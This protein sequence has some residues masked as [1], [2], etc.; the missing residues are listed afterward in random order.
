MPPQ[1]GAMSL[2][3]VAFRV[4]PSRCPDADAAICFWLGVGFRGHQPL[5]AMSHG[6]P[7]Q[8][9]S[10]QLSDAEIMILVQPIRLLQES[11]KFG[12]ATT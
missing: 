10:L 6:R 9:I 12:H 4:P 7:V 2:L 11:V 8:Q 3:D 1:L 5:L